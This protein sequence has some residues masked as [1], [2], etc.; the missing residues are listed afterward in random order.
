MKNRHVIAFVICVIIF[1]FSGCAPPKGGRE[2]VGKCYPYDLDV[3]VND[4]TMTVMWKTECDRLISGYNIYIG[5]DPLYESNSGTN[6]MSSDKP[7]N[8]EPFLGDT[9][10]SDGIEHFIASELDNG[11]RYYVSARIVFPDRSLSKPS[12]EVVAV[13]GPQREIELAIRYKSEQ[14]GFSFK[15]NCYVRA[16]DI[17]NDIYFYSKDGRDFL[18][19][20]SRLGGFLRDNSLGR[21]PFKGDIGDVKED[22][23]SLD[24]VPSSDRIAVKEGEWVRV[25]TPDRTN[26]LVKVLEITGTGSQRRVKLFI[27]YTPAK[28]SLIF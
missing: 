19:S 11:I 2:A 22:I 23:R 3:V 8:Y 4:R 28:D 27:A 20:P 14:D 5:E 15:K 25:M 9:D 13:C 18:S 7:F 10:P 12:N 16:D 17:D 26:A 24:S 6:I 1:L 21:L